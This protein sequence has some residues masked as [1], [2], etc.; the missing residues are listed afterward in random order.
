MDGEGSSSL[1]DL[2]DS[3]RWRCVRDKVCVRTIKQLV[4]EW[5]GNKCGRMSYG[6]PAG[7]YGRRQRVGNRPRCSLP[8]CI[9]SPRLLHVIPISTA[10]LKIHTATELMC[11]VYHL[12]GVNVCVCTWGEGGIVFWRPLLAHHSNE[13][14]ERFF[15]GAEA[16]ILE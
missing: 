1:Q 12:A 4:A 15:F 16:K 9:P 14:D 7:M 10:S 11:K 8:F 3:A 5:T 13:S 2:T 6:P